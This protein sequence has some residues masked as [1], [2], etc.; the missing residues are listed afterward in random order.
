M[1]LFTFLFILGIFTETTFLT[2]RKIIEKKP[3][4]GGRRKVFVDTSA[5]MDGRIL[6]IAKTGFLADDFL[7]PRS[8]V[9]E[10]QL[11]ADGKDSE[12]RARARAGMDVV[13]ELERVVFFDTEI[14]DD[15]ELGK[16]PVDERLL[17]LA[18]DNRGII[19][20]CDYNLAKVAATEKIETLNVNDL[21]ISLANNLKQGDKFRIKIIEKG[22]NPEQGVGHLN[23]GTMVVV[24]KAEKFI[25]REIEVE[26]VRFL[27]TSAGRMVFAQLSRQKRAFGVSNGAIRSTVGRSRRRG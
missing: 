11:L 16:M 19:L 15:G 26:F 20:T 7:I 22:S 14:F 18:K 8:V 5:L 9:R 23:D 3:R 25:G 13:N 24:D 27:Q 6:A 10:M 21:A 17:V 1:E 2:I 12:K 4:S